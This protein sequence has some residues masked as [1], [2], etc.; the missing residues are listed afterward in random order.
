MFGMFKHIK[1]FK[2]ELKINAERRYEEANERWIQQEQQLTEE[3]QQTK[4]HLAAERG[5]RLQAEKH[6]AE[7]R[8]CR[9]QA[10]WQHLQTW[11]ELATERGFREQLERNLA[12][13]RGRSEP[14]YQVTKLGGGFTSATV[15]AAHS[16]AAGRREHPPVPGICT[17]S[18]AERALQAANLTAR[19]A[20]QSR[21][22]AILRRRALH[23]RDGFLELLQFCGQWI[24]AGLG[25]AVA[26]VSM[27]FTVPKGGNVTDHWFHFRAAAAYLQWA[28]LLMACFGCWAFTASSRRLYNKLKDAVEDVVE[29]VVGEG[30][31]IG[32]MNA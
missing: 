21:D 8:V 4:E 5:L 26:A 15:A 31:H 17:G 24:G 16:R 28:I 1:K 11:Q 3:V 6:V 29:D 7:E 20:L 25:L 19:D 13:E 2:Q 27:A 23:R 22:S 9:L 10:Q 30:V 14:S 12:T 18:Q 32:D